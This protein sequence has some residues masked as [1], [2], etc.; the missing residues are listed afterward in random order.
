MDTVKA[1]DVYGVTHAVLYQEDHT[2]VTFCKSIARWKHLTAWWS[3][4]VMSQAD[5]GAIVDCMA[6]LVAEVSP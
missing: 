5:N 1:V 3:P 6:C 4:L 2:L